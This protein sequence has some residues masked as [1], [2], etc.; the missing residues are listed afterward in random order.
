MKAYVELVRAPAALTAVG[1]TVAGGAAA[2]TPL[3]GRRLLLPAASAAFYW[4][5]MALNDWADRELDAVERPERPIPSGR[6]SAGAAL[7]TGSA[8]T[9]AGLVLARLGGGKRAW[10]TA[11]PLAACVWAYDTT[12][13]GTAFGPVGMAACRALDVLL[14]AGGRE[15]A[16]LTA[17]GVLGVHTLGVTALSAGE[18][19]GT[20]RGTAGGALAATAVSTTLAARGT[21]GTRRGGRWRRAFTAALAGAYA[22][23]VG[24]AQYA[25]LREPSA[26]HARQAT[27][28]GIHGM[29]PLQATVA[30]RYGAVRS[31]AFLVTVLPLA[32]RLARKVSPT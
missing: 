12:L 18:V 24:G 28:A 5:G 32:R 15:R 9:A 2:G 22:S 17:A 21:G 19:H 6:V 29:V 14:G 31:A 23:S 30:A 4:A 25:A 8:L 3:R 7:A 27:K 13:K 11:V 20:S 16:A 26:R 10:R 1:D